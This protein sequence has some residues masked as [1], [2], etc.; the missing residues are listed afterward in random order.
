MYLS[1]PCSGTTRPT[2]RGCPRALARPR[3]LAALAGC[4]PAACDMDRRATCGY[5][6][7]PCMRRSRNISVLLTVQTDPTA[8]WCAAPPSVAFAP[9]AAPLLFCSKVFRL[10]ISLF[11]W[12]RRRAGSESGDDVCASNAACP[13]AE[14]LLILLVAMACAVSLTSDPKVIF[15]CFVLHVLSTSVTASTYSYQ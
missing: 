7:M 9:P 15:G 8:A 3:S 10:F 1:V 2:L 4:R 12:V 5:L 11:G 13:G 14:L 6:F